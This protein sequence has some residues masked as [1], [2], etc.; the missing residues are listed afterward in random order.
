VKHA[1]SDGAYNERR[2]ACEEAARILGA[3]KLRE[4]TATMLDAAE[5]EARLHG[6]PLRRA[7]HVVGENARVAAAVEA[8]RAGDLVVVGRLMNESHE[9]S[10]TLFENSCE[11]LDFLASEAREVPGCLGAR[12]TGGGFGGAVLALV[13]GGTEEEFVKSLGD[14]ASAAWGRVPPTL[15]TGAGGA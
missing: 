10:R 14:R 13:R 9:S 15:V 8:L 12:L 1:L 6:A 11:E 4:A 2:A 3:G 7:R 5:H